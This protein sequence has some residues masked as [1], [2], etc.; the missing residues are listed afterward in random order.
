MTAATAVTMPVMSPA[1]MMVIAVLVT[2]DGLRMQFS[3][4][5]A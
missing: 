5:L 1:A 3:I 2:A 4:M